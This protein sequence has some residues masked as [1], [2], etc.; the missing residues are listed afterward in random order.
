VSVQHKIACAN[1]DGFFFILRGAKDL[2]LNFGGYTLPKNAR[3]QLQ[4][5][6]TEVAPLDTVNITHV[7]AGDA[8]SGGLQFMVTLVLDGSSLSF[9][10]GCVHAYSPLGQA[11]P[12]TVLSTGTEDYFNSGWDFASGAFRGDQAGLTHLNLTGYHAATASGVVSFS[13][14]RIHELDPMR[15]GGGGFRLTWRNGDTVDPYSGLKCF[16]EGNGIEFITAEPVRLKAYS[17]FYT[18]DG[19]TDLKTDDDDVVREEE[20]DQQDQQQQH[21]PTDIVYDSISDPGPDLTPPSK[22][23]GPLGTTRCSRDSM[24]LGSGRVGVNA[25]VDQF[26]LAFYFATNHLTEYHSV[27]KRGRVE[28]AIEPNPFAGLDTKSFEQRLSL[29][30]GTLYISARDVSIQVFVHAMTDVINV[31]VNSSEPRHANISLGLW[32]YNHTVTDVEVEDELKGACGPG[33]DHE[34]TVQPARNGAAE[35]MFFRRNNASESVFNKSLRQQLLPELI[36]VLSGQDT[37]TEATLGGIIT[38]APTVFHRVADSKPL[39]AGIKAMLSTTAP[40]KSFTF[41]V[42]AHTTTDGSQAEWES[43]ACA[44]ADSATSAASNWDR[45][46]Q[47]WESRWRRSW[48]QVA[49]L[50]GSEGANITQAD[51][52][53]RYIDLAQG[54]G[55]YPI[56]FDGGIFAVDFPGN[57]TAMGGIDARAWG[58]EYA[59]YMDR[60]PYYAMLAAGDMESLEVYAE[61]ATRMLPFARERVRKYYSHAGAIFYEAKYYFGASLMNDAWDASEVTPKGSPQRG[62]FC[63][64]RNISQCVRLNI[65]SDT[66]DLMN[67]FG[68]H[69]Y[70]GSVEMAVLM[71]QH[72]RYTGNDTHAKIHLLP[73]ADEVLTFYYV[74]WP[75]VNG[76]LLLKDAKGGESFPNCTNP[77][78]DIAGLTA[79]LGGMLAHLPPTLLPAASRA[80]YETMQK[81]LPVLPRNG[82]SLANCGHQNAPAIEGCELLMEY[83]IWP[84]GLYSAAAN[85]S[86]FPFAVANNTFNGGCFDQ[87]LTGRYGSLPLGATAATLGH[88]ST[89]RHVLQTG[90]ARKPRTTQDGPR[91]PGFWPEGVFTDVLANTMQRLTLQRMLL[92]PDDSLGSGHGQRLLLFPAWPP[93]LDVSFKLRAQGNCTVEAVLQGGILRSLVVMPS[94][95]R[96]DIVIML[97]GL[98]PPPPAPMPPPS[99]S[100]EH[101]QLIWS[102]LPSPQVS[103][104]VN[105]KRLVL[106]HGEHLNNSTNFHVRAATTGPGPTEA[107]HTAQ[108]Y[109]VTRFS[110]VV[111]VPFAAGA[112]FEVTASQSNSTEENSAIGNRLVV[113]SPEPWWIFGDLANRSTPGGWLR[114]FGTGLQPLT[115]QHSTKLRLTSEAGTVTATITATNASRY[116]A[117]FDLPADITPGVYAVSVSAGVGSFVSPCVFESPDFVEQFHPPG[118]M[119]VPEAP[120][121]H[122]IAR[123]C[124]KTFTVAPKF[125]WSAKVFDVSTYPGA[126]RAPLLAGWNGTI[127]ASAALKACGASSDGGTVYFPRG[128]WFVRGALEVPSNCRIVGAGRQLSSIRFSEENNATRDVPPAYITNAHGGAWGILDISIYVTSFFSKVV[129]CHVQP[130]S[131]SDGTPF[132]EM[133]RVLIRAV[134]FFGLQPGGGGHRAR[135]A[136]WREDKSSN[137]D[138]DPF[139]A[140]VWLGGRNLFVTDCDL[141]SSYNVISTLQAGNRIQFVQIA[142]NKIWNGGAAHFTPSA[143]QWVFEDNKITGISTTAM[144]NNWPQY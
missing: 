82:M 81:Q 98:P 134:S 96:K 74:H 33:Y 3:L 119:P 40:Q 113:N 15:F 127:A 64:P 18:W 31:A 49:G 111:A 35:I 118:V 89:A 16:G 87:G 91:F 133:R 110:A 27:I 66:C 55:P 75:V 76:T 60:F 32:R 47:V 90:F 6:D 34:D 131:D 54:L 22:R 103:S 42:L 19:D 100:N 69:H 59:T 92:L 39:A 44:A 122:H 25:F 123:V 112:V 97:K 101:P 138:I 108:A 78:P 17:W 24:P 53:G 105:I 21:Y 70:Y 61:F 30:H 13:A 124:V 20:E 48:I 141:W 95:R 14:Y 137:G 132:F 46:A 36:P 4:K 7:V 8:R 114:V 107:W 121:F 67:I 71:L 130:G 5:I 102:S 41:A 86:E 79:L 99:P 2:P 93:E 117:W 139:P 1:P 144:G 26:G 125:T 63:I 115:P 143:Q 94:I 140:A 38:A 23:C 51:A 109:G 77:A 9:L 85:S 29:R 37:I 120:S 50:P 56:H 116:Q 57:P 65:S 10:E 68:K 142:R 58:G 128:T 83:A 104:N 72:W 80:R 62:E 84:F 135:S 45:H 136:W 88:T 73:L 12:G 106:L 43:S 126:V 28:L 129:K 11:F 52:V